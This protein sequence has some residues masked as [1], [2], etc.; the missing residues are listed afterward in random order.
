MLRHNEEINWIPGNVK[1]GQFGKWL[2]KARDWSISRNRYWGSPSAV[3]ESDNPEY[4]RMEVYG[5]LD[6]IEAACGV[7]P[8]N[9]AGEVDMD[10]PW[11]DGRERQTPDATNGHA[12]RR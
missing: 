6:E 5:S 3:W 4:P 11:I 2:E 12:V 9:A 1:H 7:L 8:R 10:R